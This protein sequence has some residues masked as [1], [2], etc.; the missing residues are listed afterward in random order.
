MHQVIGP[1]FVRLAALVAGSVL[2]VASLAET[3]GAYP[4]GSA[5]DQTA[6]G[7]PA[8]AADPGHHSLN[9]QLSVYL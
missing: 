7:D 8:A 4:F 1:R 3:A 5:I 6:G 9:G 2:L